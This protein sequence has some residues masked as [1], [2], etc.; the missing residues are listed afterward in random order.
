MLLI[1]NGKVLTMEGTIYPNGYVLMDMGKIIRLGEDVKELENAVNLK[2]EDIIDVKGCYVLPGLVDAHCHVGLWEDSVGFEGE[3]GN[4]MTDPV[5][6]HLRAIDGIYHA[7]R[8]FTEAR[9]NGCLLYTSR[10]V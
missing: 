1:C 5:T 9:E 7:D 10:C 3:D 2:K 6:P 8:A 4:E